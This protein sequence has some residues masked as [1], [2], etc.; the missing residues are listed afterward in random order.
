MIYKVPVTYAVHGF[1]TVEAENPQD[2]ERILEEG[3]EGGNPVLE[4]DPEVTSIQ[5][6]SWVAFPDMAEVGDIES[7]PIVEGDL[8]RLIQ[9]FPE[10]TWMEYDEVEQADLGEGGVYT[11]TDISDD[12]I[13]VLEAVSDIWIDMNC[14]EKVS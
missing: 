1:I 7:D 9:R 2:L 13:K 12:A 4:F 3:K 10:G 6:D 8:V 14:F 11:V 5:E